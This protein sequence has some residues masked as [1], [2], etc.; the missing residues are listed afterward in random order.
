M[1]RILFYI[2]LLTFIFVSPVYAAA[3]SY[4]FANGTSGDCLTDST[5][6]AGTMGSGGRFAVVAMG[7][8]GSATDAGSSSCD[9]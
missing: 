7:K 2:L 4:Y 5:P 1:K 3:I 9:F 8:A 6:C